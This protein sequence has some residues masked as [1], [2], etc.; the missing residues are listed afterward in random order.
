MTVIVN[1][2]NEEQEKALIEFLEKMHYDYQ[3]ETDFVKLSEAQKEEI[4]KRDNDFLNGKTTARNW[5]DIKNE[6]K[7][8]Y[9]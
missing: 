3:N 7:S 5:S 2:H 1:L 6:L 4:L 9:R 8:V